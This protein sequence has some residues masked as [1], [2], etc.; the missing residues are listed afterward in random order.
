MGTSQTGFSLIEALLTLVIL[1]VGLLGIGQLQARLWVSSGQLHAEQT[2]FLVGESLLEIVALSWLPEAEKQSS[3]TQFHPAIRAEVSH[4]RL[5]FPDDLLTSTRVDVGW[6]SPSGAR[7]L[8]VQNTVNTGL[9]PVDTR[10]LLT[11][12]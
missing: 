5:P 1:S 12:N 9:D 11:H 4:H 8:S 6:T 7:S 2:A 3:A 10:W